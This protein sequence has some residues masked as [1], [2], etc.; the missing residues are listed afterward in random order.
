MWRHIKD[1]LRQRHWR[2][3]YWAA[4]AQLDWL[5]WNL[6]CLL[7]SGTKKEKAIAADLLDAIGK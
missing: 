6:Q 5:E 3:R 7:E 1:W 4:E 2:E